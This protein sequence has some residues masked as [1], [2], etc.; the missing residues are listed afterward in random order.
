VAG[1]QLD[2]GEAYAGS[3]LASD[4]QAA[5]Q[6][7]FAGSDGNLPTLGTVVE[8]FRV[9]LPAGP[10]LT[11]QAVLNFSRG[12]EFDNQVQLYVTGDTGELKFWGLSDGET[13]WAFTHPSSPI[14]G[15]RHQIEASWGP[16]FAQLSVDG[17]SIMNDPLIANSPAFSLDRIDVSFSSNSSGS[18]EGLVAGIEIGTR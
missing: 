5:D 16:S 3:L 18:L 12:G 13:H 1:L 8:R 4:S 6:L 11:D 2:V 14:D 15:L 9:L 10:R 17:T 7:S